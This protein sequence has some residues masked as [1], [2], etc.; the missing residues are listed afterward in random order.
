M[1][2]HYTKYLSILLT[3]QDIWSSLRSKLY[4]ETYRCA[5]ILENH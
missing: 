3:L 5:I 4:L 1:V 2:E